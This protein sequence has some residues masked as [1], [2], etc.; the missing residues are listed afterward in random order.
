MNKK[1]LLKVLLL[2]IILL[3]ISIIIYKN[4]NEKTVFTNTKSNDTANREELISILQEKWGISVSVSKD[5]KIYEEDPKSTPE[6]GIYI[7][8]DNI[9]SK[10]ISEGREYIYVY[11]STGKIPIMLYKNTIKEEFITNEKVK[12]YLCITKNSFK[13][14]YTKLQLVLGDGFQGAFVI[15]KN[16]TYDKINSK[17]TN[18]LKSII[19]KNEENKLFKPELLNEIKG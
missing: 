1:R 2:T 4:N 5:V 15:C 10:E 19:L 18:I 11:G 7:F 13:E 9:D 8:L 16:E 3:T 6:S 12:G 14:G 17:I